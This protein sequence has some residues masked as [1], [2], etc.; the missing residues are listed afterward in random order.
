M[1][2]VPVGTPSLTWI[3]NDRAVAFATSY[4]TSDTVLGTIRRLDVSGPASGNLMADSTVIWS[5]TVPWNQSKGCFQV[6]DW[7]PLI[8]A[9]GN[10]ISCLTW[11]MPVKTPGMWTSTPTRS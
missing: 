9:D 7:P 2:T 1:A 4:D 11:D 10:T 3:D 5:G 8:S 6:D